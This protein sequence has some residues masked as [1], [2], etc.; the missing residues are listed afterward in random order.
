MENCQHVN[1]IWL[2]VVD[3]AVRPFD[4]FT[5]LEHFELCNHAAVEGKSAI[6]CDR[7]VKRS[8]VLRA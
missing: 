4:Q 2:E 1:L 5:D 3:D 8:T 6:C 7:R